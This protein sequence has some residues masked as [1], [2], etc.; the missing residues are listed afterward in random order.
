MTFSH[1]NNSPMAV[2]GGLWASVTP[3]TNDVTTMSAHSEAHYIASS[4][5]AKHNPILALR[6]IEQG[7]PHQKAISLLEKSPRA[8]SN[9]TV[10]KMERFCPGWELMTEEMQNMEAYLHS[11]RTS[12]GNGYL[13][14]MNA[15]TAALNKFIEPVT[16]ED[17]IL[18]G[19]SADV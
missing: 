1:L 16:A 17:F 9:Y 19:D 10:R 6:L 4:E 7:I 18:V 3:V 11:V 2:A 12:D 8:L 14:C 5:P 13:A 15:A